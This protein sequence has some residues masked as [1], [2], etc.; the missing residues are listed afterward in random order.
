MKSDVKLLL[1]GDHGTGKSSLIS[2]YISQRFDVVPSVLTDAKLPAA[3]T[4]NGVAVTIMDSSSRLS[5]GGDH[6][7]RS[8]FPSRL[9]MMFLTVFCS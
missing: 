9:T 4:A 1:I 6:G 7:K 5:L 8:F 2:T 3:T